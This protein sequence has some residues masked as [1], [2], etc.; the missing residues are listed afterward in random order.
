MRLET[1]GGRGPLG[2]FCSFGTSVANTQHEESRE[3]SKGIETKTK[4]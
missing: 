1:G 4:K 3:A 2:R